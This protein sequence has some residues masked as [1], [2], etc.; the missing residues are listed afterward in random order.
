VGSLKGKTVRKRAANVDLRTVDIPASLIIQYQEVVLAADV[1]F[2]NKIPFFVTISR[3]IKFGT[4]KLL[5]NQKTDAL[6]T[7]LS[8]ALRIY[9][10]Q[11]SSPIQASTRPDDH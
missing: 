7:A 3:D 2:V 9:K 6:K 11:Y 4:S 1:M 10:T 5:P 8:H